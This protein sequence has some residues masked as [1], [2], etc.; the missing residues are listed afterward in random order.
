MFVRVP[1][2]I[3]AAFLAW[4]AVWA[5]DHPPTPTGLAETLE[6]R[7]VQLD[8]GVEG[9]PDAIRG[10]TAKDFVLY[11][12][13]HEVQGLIVDRLCGDAPPLPESGTE[14]DRSADGRPREAPSRPREAAHRPQ[15]MGL[16]RGNR[17]RAGQGC[18]RCEWPKKHTLPTGEKLRTRGMT[19]GKAEHGTH[20]DHRRRR[21]RGA[22]AKSSRLLREQPPAEGRSVLPTNPTGLWSRLS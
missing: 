5:A 2:L 16:V 19:G 11:V 3:A 8:V 4:V 7:L 17:G 20:R 9:D 18:R 6:K 14:D 15:A 13:E 21:C 1:K 22:G 12:G 10:I